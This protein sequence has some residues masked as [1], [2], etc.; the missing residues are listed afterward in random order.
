MTAEHV[1]GSHGRL[2][3]LQKSQPVF[4]ELRAGP[5]GRIEQAL[6][7]LVVFHGVCSEI[8]RNEEVV[9][10]P[11]DARA[12]EL[13]QQVDAFPRL[14][15]A[16]GDVAER[17]D[18]VDVVSLDIRERCAESDGVSVHVG[19]KGDPHPAELTDTP[20]TASSSASSAS[21]T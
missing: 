1:A 21:G 19:E 16:L 7:A 12:A 8:E 9:G 5:V 15:P 18:Q 14:R 13:A 3:V 6:S 4:A 11:V 20:Y 10:V 2:E 17:D